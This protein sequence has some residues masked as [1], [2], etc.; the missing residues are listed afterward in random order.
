MSRR[1]VTPEAQARADRIAAALSGLLEDEPK[2]EGEVPLRDDG[3]PYRQIPVA[4]RTRKKG[5]A[6]AGAS[7]P[8]CPGTLRL[9]YA[10][11]VE[12]HRCDQCHGLWLDPGE[13]EQLVEP[14][15]TTPLSLDPAHI[16]A[17]MQALVPEPGKVR[18]RN[19]PRCAKPMNRRNFADVSG[20]I[21]DECPVHGIFLDPGEFEA[22]DTFA[23]LG[24]FELQRR[25]M[26]E[27]GRRRQRQ[28]HARQTATKLNQTVD[29]E[30][31]R[32]WWQVLFW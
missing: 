24:G 4:P 6:R 29:H 10:R 7:C 2:R 31:A 22:I 15:V 8:A 32:F 17:R 14:S 5:K 11:G 25:R 3:D 23:K 19:C 18:Y 12:I 13:V 16:R 28:E 1:P 26:A 27:Q 9:T 21:V 30:Q 20:V